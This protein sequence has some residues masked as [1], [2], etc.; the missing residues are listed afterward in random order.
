MFE[1]GK[2]SEG[3]APPTC[4]Q[5]RTLRQPDIPRC[6][7]HVESYWPR[8]TCPLVRLVRDPQSPIIEGLLLR[9]EIHDTDFEICCVIVVPLDES[10]P[11]VEIVFDRALYRRQSFEK[12]GRLS[13]RKSRAN[14]ES[15]TSQERR[16]GSLQRNGASKS[17]C[18]IMRWRVTAN[19]NPIGLTS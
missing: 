16:R 18:P 14:A 1:A 9:T 17:S 13:P 2:G 5:P 6:D 4:D 15:L 12:P 7:P 10:L 3:V 11:L 19:R 8:Y